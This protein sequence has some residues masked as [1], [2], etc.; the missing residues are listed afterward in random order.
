MPAEHAGIRN[1]IGHE[2]DPCHGLRLSRF[3]IAIRT[4]NNLRL[5]RWSQITGHNYNNFT[6]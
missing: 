4:V 5:A 6:I 1:H 2:P 3:D